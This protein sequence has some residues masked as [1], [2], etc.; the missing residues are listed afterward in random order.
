MRQKYVGKKVAGMFLIGV[1]CIAGTS[2]SVKALAQTNTQVLVQTADQQSAIK[3][4]H[5]KV[6]GIPQ[7]HSTD[8]RLSMGAEMFLETEL[9]REDGSVETANSKMVEWSVKKKDGSSCRAVVLDKTPADGTGRISIYAPYGQP[10]DLIVTAKVGDVTAEHEIT[11]F[12]EKEWN[13]D[14][15]F[16]FQLGKVSSKDVSMDIPEETWNAE[17]KSYQIVLPDVKDMQ[18][19][20]QG[21]GND[22][23][24]WKEAATGKIYK[25]GTTIER[26]YKG[27]EY[28]IFTAQWKELQKGESFIKGD[29]MYR[30]TSDKKRKK[31][32][33]FEKLAYQAQCIHPYKIPDTVNYDGITYKVTGIA[34]HALEKTGLNKITIG[35][36]V[37][38]ISAKA[39]ANCKYL[40][41][42][43][44]QSRQLKASGVGKNAFAGI[45]KNVTIQCPKEKVH[46]YT[47]LFR[48]AGL[49]KNV[50]IKEK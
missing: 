13:G 7:D 1:L 34:A 29:A 16:R 35:K 37:I 26:E 30:V 17:K 20:T 8:R 40:K 21:I 33:T 25:G 2:I 31:E 11:T 3:A 42:I 50:T 36:N 23:L 43:V 28:V 15:Y 47:K 5:I 22:F 38:T 19:Y 9:E 24:G 49:K 4:A 10:E 46:S 32:V 6:I 27:K 12:E 39:F 18:I 44:I 45:S 41:K 14:R 48:K